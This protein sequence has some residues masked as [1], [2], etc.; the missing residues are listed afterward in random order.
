MTTRKH[1]NKKDGAKT[2]IA[3]NRKVRNKIARLNRHLKK[4]PKDKQA[5]HALAMV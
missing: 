1:G 3:E 5:T 4:Q 2:Y